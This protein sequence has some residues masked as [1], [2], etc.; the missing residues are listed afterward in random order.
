[1]SIHYDKDRR[2]YFVQWRELNVTTGKTTLRRKRGFL[3]KRE[4]KEFEANQQKETSTLFFRDVVDEFIESIRGYAS[5][6]TI[7]SKK[8][9]ITHYCAEFMDMDVKDIDKQMV[10]K[11]KNE[12]AKK[13]IAIDTKNQILTNFKSVGKYLYNFHDID[14]FTKILKRFP[15]TSEDLS[16]M[17]IISPEDFSLLMSKVDNPEFRNF[18][19]FLYH[20]GMRRGEAMGLKKEAVDGRFVTIKESVRRKGKNTLKNPNS[21]RTILI[22]ETAYKCI[23]PYLDLDG[24]YVFG[25]YEPLAPQ[26]IVNHWERALKLLNQ[27]KEIGHIRVHDLRHSFISNAIMNGANIVTVSRYVGH[28]DTTI[29][30]NTYAHLLQGSQEDMLKIL[31]GVY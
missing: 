6:D 10:L 20:T 21:R 28:K 5:E 17:H 18:F 3:T 2:T 4:A 25:Q 1:M 30:L 14:N 23:E 12:L 8:R 22:D 13:P 15:K 27:E 7:Y 26:S 11:W 16:E 19:T 24:D 31:E 29:T 9:Q